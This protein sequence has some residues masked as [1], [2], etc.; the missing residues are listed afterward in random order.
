M[1]SP[2]RL[3]APLIALADVPAV[4]LAVAGLQSAVVLV[5]QWPP[6]ADRWVR[7]FDRDRYG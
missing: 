7:L 2:T 5:M 4:T 6:A 1:D 3:G